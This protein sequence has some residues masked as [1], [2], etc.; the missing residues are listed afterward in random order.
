MLK[1]DDPILIKDG[2]TA[3]SSYTSTAEKTV[4]KDILNS[5]LPPIEKKDL[6]GN[7]WIQ[8]IS[9]K[10]STLKDIV[11][12]QEFIDLKLQQLQIRETGIDTNRED[13][14]LQ[15]FNECIRQITINCHERGLLLLKIRNELQN[16]ISYYKEL[17][18]SSIAFGIR[19]NLYFQANLEEQVQ[20]KQNL[21]KEIQQLKNEYEELQEETTKLQQGDLQN[22]EKKTLHLKYID[23]LNE[24]IDTLKKSLQNVLSVPNYLKKKK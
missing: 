14:Y 20:R 7:L 18:T 6:H 8:Y 4:T 12:I 15:C 10:P 23:Q 21:K 24:Q 9:S 22:N 3:S 16:Y 1:Y 5:I 19:K 13:L 11:N 2:E 17:Y